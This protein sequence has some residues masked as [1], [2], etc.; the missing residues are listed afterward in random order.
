MSLHFFFLWIVKSTFASVSRQFQLKVSIKGFNISFIKKVCL[1]LH[2]QFTYWL[3]RFAF[4]NPCY[5]CIVQKWKCITSYEFHTFICSLTWSCISFISRSLWTDK[6]AEYSTINALNK[7]IIGHDFP[8]RTG[9]KKLS[10]TGA[11]Y[12]MTSNSLR[13]KVSLDISY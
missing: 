12:W 7:K 1:A 4:I 10:D 13:V 8:W 3:G 2:W 6:Y 11:R 5:V 9:L